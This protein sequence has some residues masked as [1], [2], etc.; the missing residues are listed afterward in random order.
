MSL[1][2]FFRASA[3]ES[4]TKNYMNK[5]LIVLLN[6]L[7][8]S[9]AP[10]PVHALV[11]D[12][13]Q[14]VYCAGNSLKIVEEYE[15]EILSGSACTSLILADLNTIL[16][17]NG[18][19]K[20]ISL[21]KELTRS[22]VTDAEKV[23][24]QDVVR[25][26][27]ELHR[28]DMPKGSNI[29][30][31]YDNTKERIPKSIV[32]L[33]YSNNTFFLSGKNK[34]SVI[35]YRNGFIPV[36][37]YT[38]DFNSIGLCSGSFKADKPVIISI[39]SNMEYVCYINGKKVCVNAS[40]D[41]KRLI[42]MFHVTPDDGFTVAVYYKPAEDM[43]LKINF[44]DDNYHSMDLADTE[45]T[46]FHDVQWYESFYE[47][48]NLL[49]SKYS[50]KRSADT[51]LQLALFYESLQSLE[52][53]KYYNEALRLDNKNEYIT[54]RYVS[55]L[56][57]NKNIPGSE[58]LIDDVF[59]KNTTYTSAL[60]KYFNDC[61]RHTQPGDIMQVYYLPM[62]LYILKYQ[63]E[64]LL[65]KKINIEI[66]LNRYP[67]SNDLRYIVADVISQYDIQKAITF[68]EAI[69]EPGDKEIG[70]LLQMYEQ[71]R[72]YEKIVSLL[73]ESTTDRYFYEYIHTLIALKRYND[74]K[75]ELFKK[76]AQGFDTQVY[77]LLAMIADL[78]DSD[79]SMYRQ[80]HEVIVSGIPFHKDY[81]KIY[82]DDYVQ[83]TVFSRLAFETIQTNTDG[84]RYSCY[85]LR[86]I[87]NSVY[88]YL[89]D[90]YYVNDTR[91]INEYAFGKDIKITQCNVY[92]VN[93][94]DAIEKKVISYPHNQLQQR[95]KDY[96]KNNLYRY[97]LVE[98]AF[99]SSKSIPVM[100][101]Q[102]NYALSQF[103]MD[104][105]AM[106]PEAQSCVLSEIKGDV[107]IGEHNLSHHRFTNYELSTQLQRDF[108]VMALTPESLIEWSN[109][110]QALFKRADYLVSDTQLNS[111]TIEDSAKELV[112]K[113][114]LFTIYK[115][116][117]TA[118]SLIELTGCKKGTLLDAMLYARYMLAKNGIMS[119]IG[120][121]CSDVCGDKLNI[122][123]T[124]CFD[125]VLLYVP[126]TAEKGIW[127]TG[128]GTYPTL[129]EAHINNVFLIVGDEIIQKSVKK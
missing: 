107:V 86:F 92:T 63:K 10:L 56:L 45:N 68:L 13:I 22:A 58:L 6:T 105:I 96:L 123:N 43:F 11:S 124:L 4:D 8:L 5:I 55:L 65:R 19:D 67:H 116:P 41:K 59:K 101:I 17:I 82:F 9:I 126:L 3:L 100:H 120:F 73:K 64:E 72:L 57:G 79:G 27:E 48:E 91:Q 83:K 87:D 98:I 84:L 93:E 14:H 35:D 53:L 18:P 77:S 113:I 81:M 85:A 118:T 29:W 103:D 24:V 37:Q 44:N 49:R 110:Q 119:Y 52:A 104:I 89:Y 90:I 115:H 16:Q 99:Q 66:L 69:Q 128:D 109:E 122:P 30:D 78:E 1:I 70:L 112:Q 106:N 117:Y 46:Y 28:K 36:Q 75:R 15:N 40:T 71:E 39:Y 76:I 114:Q 129:D 108:F 7:I 34:I 23:Y 102:Q 51:T 50:I 21:L 32:A 127:L 97:A 60:W 47:Y 125:T 2:Q 12:E 88:C 42:R 31:I 121:G 111:K 38:Q 20:T 33:Q 95:L 26:F 61:I 62:L 74:A 25:L 94:N 80:K 54:C